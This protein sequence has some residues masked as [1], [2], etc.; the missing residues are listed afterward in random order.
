MLEHT[1]ERVTNICRCVGAGFNPTN[2][3]STRLNVDSSYIVVVEVDREGRYRAADTEISAQQLMTVAKACRLEPKYPFGKQAILKANTHFYF[4]FFLI[5]CL[6][7]LAY[8]H[9]TT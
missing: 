5:F 3:W 1:V 8:L 4:L 2:C 7:L 6:Y 9:G